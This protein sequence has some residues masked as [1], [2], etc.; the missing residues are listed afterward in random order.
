M[1]KVSVIIPN[2]NHERFLTERID[3]VLNQTYRDFEVILLDDCSTDNSRRIISRYESHPLVRQTIFN[4]SNSGSTF[5]Q[6]NKGARVAQGEYLW[7]A[8]SDDCAEPDFLA[9]M[10]PVL[11]EHPT[12]GVVKCQSR[13]IDLDGNRGP[14]IEDAVLQRDWSKPFV[15]AGAADCVEQLKWGISI[16][17]ASAALV[18]KKTY[19]EAG[20][21]DETFR[22]AGDWMTWARILA[23]SDFAYIA[24]PLN[25]MR[26]AHAH[27]ARMKF[28]TTHDGMY[29]HED[30]R[31]VRFI[32]ENCPVSRD[33]ASKAVERHIQRWVDFVVTLHGTH[34]SLER[35]IKILREAYAI[36][37]R[38]PLILVKQLLCRPVRAVKRRLARRI[39]RRGHGIPS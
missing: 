13:S 33:A 14:I 30:L 20:W 21:A 25:L 38:T 4:E 15:M 27:T 2:Y 19:V 29:F 32:V 5:K 1:P 12:V 3:S 6:W 34:I 39:I 35:S 11:E 16:F 26:D 8:E 7:F 10:V 28:M 22:M 18:R 17:N 24:K 36:S 9:E 31:V 23:R 37:K